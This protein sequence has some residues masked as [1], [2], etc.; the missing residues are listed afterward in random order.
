MVKRLPQPLI[1]YAFLLVTFLLSASAFAEPKFKQVKPQF[2]AALVAPDA[3]SGTG[4]ET[5]GL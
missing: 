4:A 3:T 1:V 5:C 2:T